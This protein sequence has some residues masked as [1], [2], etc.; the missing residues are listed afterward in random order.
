MNKAEYRFLNALFLR[1]PYYSFAGYDPERLPEVLQDPAFRNALY[2]ASPGFYRVIEASG[3]D[4]RL[5]GAKEKH[6]LCKYYNRMCF[7]PTPFGS[8]ASFTLL[9]WGEG[10]NVKLCGD[11][12]AILHLLPDR[13][14]IT[15]LRHLTGPFNPAKPLIRN[16]T[17][18]RMGN[19]YRYVKSTIDEKGHYRFSLDALAAEDFYHDFFESFAAGPR[20]TRQVLEWMTTYSGCSDDEA[21]DY[22]LFL[23]EEQVLYH[24]GTGY[25]ISAGQTPSADDLQGLSGNWQTFKQ[26]PF[27]QTGSLAGLAAELDPKPGE[28]GKEGTKSC[29]YAALERK[30]QSGGLSVQDKEDLGAAIQMLSLFA[31][32]SPLTVLKKFTAAFKARF[33]L[34]QVPLLTA[35]DPDAGISYGNFG[36]SSPAKGFE[37]IR[38]PA[39][40][41]HD[42][43]VDWT[44]VH[45][46]LFRLWGAARQNGPFSPLMITEDDLAGLPATP[47][48]GFLP[49]TLAVMFRKT[50]DHLLIE[51]AGGAA[52]AALTGRFSAFSDETK[53]LCRKLT[54]LEAAAHP[55]I[56]FSDIGVLSDTHTD[57]INYRER[58]YPFE[59]PLNVYSALPEEARIPPEDLLLSVR[60]DE[61]ILSSKRLQKRV[62]PRLST[63]YNYQHNELAVFRLLCDMQ[64]QGLRSNFNFNMAYYFPGQSFYPRV[65]FGNTII[66]LARWYLGEK[67]LTEI[68]GEAPGKLTSV[69]RHFRHRYGIPQR[70]S[71]GQTDQQLFF[72]L[73]NAQEAQFF[74]D[75]IKDLKTVTLTEYLLPGRAVKTGNKPLAGQFIAFLSHKETIYQQAAALKPAA[76]IDRQRH[77]LLGDDWLYVKIYC[78]PESANR[79]L[80]T[81]IMP[82]IHENR[83]H[84]AKWFFIRYFDTGYHLRFRI[85]TSPERPGLLLHELRKKLAETGNDHLVKDYQGDIYRREMER[86]GAGLIEPVETFFCAGSELVSRF[87]Q[88]K[89]ESEGELDEFQLALYSTKRLLT[90]FLDD[91]TTGLDFTKQMS[92]RYLREFA[93]DQQLKIDL[94]RKYRD[95]KT[96]ISNLFEEPVFNERLTAL[97]DSLCAALALI[98]E[99]ARENSLTEQRA[100]LAD[101]VHMHLNRIFMVKQRQQELLVYYL[102][103]KY[104]A[105]VTARQTQS[106]QTS[107]TR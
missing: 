28:P 31:L 62:I 8:F 49:S 59:I 75:C 16:P 74:M 105:S 60:N 73:A 85:L 104:W 14:L 61:L 42:V 58:I 20:Q 25:I 27:Q 94:D 10:E 76:G 89:N 53:V 15:R 54:A 81:V 88:I 23:L 44:P 39:K 66:S 36:I 98:R 57:N 1:A 46:L 29:F 95:M 43:A 34:E 107:S 79:I 69:L 70:V 51:H 93:A 12:G 30:K 22:L 68:R 87:V 40:P 7:R 52:A 99:Q 6:S 90:V 80:G 101:L 2:L 11:S 84:L 21:T 96:A 32:A 5:L 100:L 65:V 82:F 35:L 17:L 48:P 103:Q 26:I 3:F 55:G 83:A 38:F 4:Y 47:G 92:A 72:D 86:Y 37:D 77:F 41:D 19:E 102:L 63:A 24:P 97:L 33:D 91:I 50:E 71:I 106:R 45:N 56:V 64:Y 9:E 78:T 67:E 13:Q 18:Y